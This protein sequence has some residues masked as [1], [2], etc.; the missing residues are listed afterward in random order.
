M[1]KELQE[2]KRE[3]DRLSHDL[4]SPEKLGA[5]YQ[6][7]A[8]RLKQLIPIVTKFAELLK[9]E[10]QIKEAEEILEEHKEGE[11]FELA[12]G[13]LPALSERHRCI[14][15]EVSSLLSAQK[16]G[17]DGHKTTGVIVEIRAGA[18]GEE[19]ALFAR[20]LF[21]M[22][23]RFAEKRE[24]KREVINFHESEIRGFKEIIFGL[25]GKD[26]YKLMRREGGV[27]R[28]QRIPVTESSGRIHTSTVTVAVLPEIEE[29]QLDLNQKDLKIDV[30][31]AS[32]A[33]GQHVNVTDSA[34][35]IVHLPT[36]ITVQCQDERSQH[37]NRAKAM[38]VLRA[39]VMEHYRQERDAEI[40]KDRTAQVKKG[41]RS[42]KIRTY[43]FPQNRL[44]DHRINLRI[45]KLDSVM[46]GELD[47]LFSALTEN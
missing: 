16:Q 26:V 36:G 20:D 30:F 1:I 24:W 10:E 47:E 38:R 4:L 2:L 32:G 5:Q 27:H 34:V 23:S 22:Y 31:R 43:N 9:V 42:E 6:K 19:A 29:I 3:H 41:D 25:E 17:D 13:E 45:H 11:L 18:G 8:L 44:T 33:G 46:K 7:K 39:R 35:R 21:Q 37:K 28:V 12:E 15:G 14:K 40:A